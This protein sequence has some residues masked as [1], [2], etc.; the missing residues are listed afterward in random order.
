MRAILLVFLFGCAT[1]TPSFFYGETGNPLYIIDSLG[2]SHHI[3]IQDT[4]TW[5][6]SHYVADDSFR[7][8][9]HLFLTEKGVERF[10][11]SLTNSPEGTYE[12]KL[13]KEKK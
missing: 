1:F 4:S 5:E 10:I 13:R 2:L 12:V 7:Y 9:Q 3:A 8:T 11:I 6:R